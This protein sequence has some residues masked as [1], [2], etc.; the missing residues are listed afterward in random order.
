MVSESY[1]RPC[2]RDLG[3]EAALSSPTPEILIL[4]RQISDPRL[5]QAF[6][7]VNDKLELILK[8]FVFSEDG[9]IGFGFHPAFSA[10]F[11]LN[12]TAAN[13]P[14]KKTGLGLNNITLNDKLN[15]NM[16]AKGLLLYDASNNVLSYYNGQNWVNIGQSLSASGTVGSSAGIETTL[17]ETVL[18]ASFLRNDGDSFTFV[19]MG[20][21]TLSGNN[22]TWRVRL[23]ASRIFEVSGIWDNESIWGFGTCLRTGPT[24]QQSGGFAMHGIAG[25]TGGGI[26]SIPFLTTEIM[27]DELILKLTGLGASNN[28]CVGYSLRATLN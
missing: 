23:G 12:S 27:A 19:F 21:N 20:Y 28:D 18:P 10:M 8:S 16:P 1:H 2:S 15:I 7:E 9:R 11:D 6:K 13:D 26:A 24:S 14:R 17:I 25:A 22:K 4:G 3:R 5:Y